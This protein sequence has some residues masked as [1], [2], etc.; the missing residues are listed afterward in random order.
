MSRAYWIFI[1][2]FCALLGYA[3]ATGNFGILPR[4]DLPFGRQVQ[5]TSAMLNAP[6]IYPDLTGPV[7]ITAL[8]LQKRLELF[9]A[10]IK[11]DRSNDDRGWVM[12][13]TIPVE[14][15]GKI[16]EGAIRFNF[17]A[18]AKRGGITGPGVLVVGW[19]E[20]GST[21]NSYELSMMLARYAA[22]IHQD[23][24]L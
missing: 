17:L 6:L 10:K 20:D 19:G 22:A 2:C 16:A 7:G 21:M 4:I 14:L 1:V 11:W 5:P 3:S 9:D 13:Y 23:G 8:Q 12:R 24:Q 15:T 18:D